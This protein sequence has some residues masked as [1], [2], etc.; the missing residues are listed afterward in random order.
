M[1]YD[2]NIFKITNNN[3]IPEKGCILI[4]EPFLSGKYFERSVVFLVEH[5]EGQG[6]MGFVLNKKI[7]EK[8]NDFFPE[9]KDIPDISIFRGGPVATDR[10]YYI[11][12]LGSIIPD[13]YEVA[14][15]IYLGGDFEII[16]S[17]IAKGN[18][19]EGI[20]KFFLGYSGWEK[21]QLDEEIALNSWLVS[22]TEQSKIMKTEGDV[23]WKK[24]LQGLGDKY[25]S[26][27]NF[28]KRPFLN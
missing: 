9:L 11:H 12:T 14:D 2:K 6:T 13:T 24:A 28:P 16:K 1:T 27:A 20:I 7:K 17:Y 18:P 22:K 23:L 5:G 26:W 10:L 3:V 25:Q 19:V 15:G 4:A 21:E 8:L